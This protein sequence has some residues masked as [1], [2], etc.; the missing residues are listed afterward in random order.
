MKK[1]LGII[2]LLAV[3]ALVLVIIFFR[4]D[5]GF[6][7]INGDGKKNDT[8]VSQ[9]VDKKGT[10][11][12]EE[13]DIHT[14]EIMVSGH[15]YLFNNEK[16]TLDSLVEK[17]GKLEKDVEI[18]ITYDDTAAKNTMDDLTDKLDE[19]GYKYTKSSK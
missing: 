6:G 11:T 8:S 18:A 14:A 19:L 17:I 13:K 7:W 9:T 3:V 5:I 16:I 1:V 2:L 4:G 12:L 15:D 10:T